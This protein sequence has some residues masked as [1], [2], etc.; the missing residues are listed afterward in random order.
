M[1]ETSGL[2]FDRIGIRPPFRLSV[3]LSCLAGLNRNGLFSRH[4]L[5]LAAGRV[6]AEPAAAL[7][8]P[9]VAPQEIGGYPMA[10]VPI[11]IATP[12]HSAATTTFASVSFP[13]WSV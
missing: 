2:Y 3:W 8:A 4:N 12:M 13:F 5:P 11:A 9:P 6:I 1:S 7:T 10:I